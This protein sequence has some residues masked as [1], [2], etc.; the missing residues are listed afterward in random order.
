[1]RY[2][3]F[4]RAVR[5]YRP[6]A[7]L[8]LLARTSISQLKTHPLETVN[9]RDPIKPWAIS[10]VAREAL[11]GGAHGAGREQPT[12]Q[13]LRALDAMVIDLED[14]LSLDER[15]IVGEQ[16]ITG[17]MLRTGYQQ[18]P[19]Q[20]PI[21]GDTARMRPMLKRS[22]PRPKYQVL[23]DEVIAEILGADI[24]TYTDLAPFFL[25]AVMSNGG[26]FD[27]TWLDR[28]HFAPICET[29]SKE[30]ILRVYDTRL[31]APIATLRESARS[32]RHQR[33]E[34]RQHDFNPL[35]DA[36]FAVLPDG[37]GLAPQPAFVT[38]RFSMAALYYA[39]QKQYGNALATDLGHVNEEYTVEQLSLLNQAGA[40][41]CGEITYRDRKAE[42]SSVDG[43]VTYPDQMIFVEVKSLRPRMDQRLD[44]ASYAERLR[45]DFVKAKDQLVT[46]YDLWRGGHEAFEGL[47]PQ[48][49]GRAVRGLIVVPEPL[50]LAN[51]TMFGQVIG[52]MPFP[53]AVVSLTQLEDLVAVA[54]AERSGRVFQDVTA[55]SRHLVADPAAALTAARER[56]GVTVSRNEI[57]DASFEAIRWQKVR[58]RPHG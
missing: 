10:L 19:Y 24:D 41:V 53:T 23:S 30:Q 7:L 15:A 1:M 38:G 31:S 46:T 44:P 49:E 3:E 32:G 52:A 25:A 8:R 40:A 4:V 57:L 20:Q 13:A 58:N 17:F 28:P 35:V 12:L 34:L 50:Y 6:I 14:P 43:I 18:F 2:D 39:G 42:K 22:F 47:P 27:R 11:A 37:L 9:A 54:V 5:R 45:R 55:G 56:A 51:H 29:V 33:L 16:E 26:T 21:Y 36:P 48:S